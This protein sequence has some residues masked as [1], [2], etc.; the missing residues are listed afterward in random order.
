MRF[1]TPGPT[2]LSPE[3]KP[4]IEQALKEDI[5]SISHRSKDFERIFARMTEGLR[6]LLKIPSAH[7]IFV[8][9]S[10]TECWERI[11]ENCSQEHSF[12][13]VNGAFSERFYTIALELKRKALKHEVA[14]GQGADLSTLAIPA[15]AEVICL[16][17]N[18][19]STGVSLPENAVSALKRR[20]PE[21]LLAIDI[22]SSAPIVDLN[23]SDIDCGFFS[24]QKCF[25]LPA[26]LGILIASPAALAKAEALQ[27]AG[28]SIGSYHSFP[29]LI[30]FVK[31]N[32]TPETPNVLGIFLLGGVVD[33]FNREGIEKVRSDIRSRS[34][35]IYSTFTDREGFKIFVQDPR[36]RSATVLTIE[37]IGG[38]SGLVARLA[39]QGLE[40]G[41]GYGKFKDSQIRI[42][43]FP[44]HS[45]DDLEELLKAITG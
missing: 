45:R 30:S 35:Q 5:G 42:A 6:A 37:V 31:K 34:E 18:E 15:E 16:T 10:A 29:S 12:H 24:V 3:I 27:R 23:W 44:M 33:N 40:V 17:H 25:G 20:Y 9:G 41:S 1:F 43:N 11:I 21:K 19:T 39:K 4:L 38:S 28:V 36:Y 32:Q 13:L 8:L 22:V 26:G 2:H 14:P 7:Q